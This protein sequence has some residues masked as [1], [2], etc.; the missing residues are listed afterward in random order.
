M[1]L[2]QSQ[3]IIVAHERSRRKPT[4][5]RS[6]RKP[7]SE[8][9]KEKPT[10]ECSKSKRVYKIRKPQNVGALIMKIHKDFF[11]S[12]VLRLTGC[13]PIRRLD[14]F[15]PPPLLLVDNRRP[16]VIHI[17]TQ[18]DL[19]HLAVP[20]TCTA[21]IT[22][23]DASLYT[24][25]PYPES[26]LSLPSRPA[27]SSPLSLRQ[28]DFGQGWVDAVLQDI[29]NTT[30]EDGTS[31]DQLSGLRSPLPLL[32]TN[33]EEYQQHVSIPPP[34]VPVW[35]ASQNDQGTE[36]IPPPPP[37][38]T[39]ASVRSLEWFMYSTQLWENIPTNPFRSLD[40]RSSPNGLF[41]PSMSLPIQ[42]V[43]ET[44]PLWRVGVPNTFNFIRQE[45]VLSSVLITSSFWR[46]EW[47][48]FSNIPPP[49]LPTPSLWSREWPNYPNDQQQENV[50][51][52][53]SAISPFE[54]LD[55]FD[56]QNDSE[57]ENGSP[58]LVPEGNLE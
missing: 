39:I 8:P 12:T 41:S 17:T 7:T 14:M 32:L 37:F 48:S 36:N 23:T 55:W 42:P 30:M 21:M 27:F 5:K 45:N 44:L 1:D 40:M 49:V 51:P 6:R 4:S 2:D 26:Q 43:P 31:Q 15:R 34:P 9:S 29:D 16:S 10:N 53:I 18:P 52:S 33:G 56:P 13:S 28:Q 11:M 19:V 22:S 3:A 25:T 47:H 50:P 20:N 58:L 35:P 38:P 24:R 57:L 54:N 46:Q